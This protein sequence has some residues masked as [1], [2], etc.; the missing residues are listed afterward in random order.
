MARITAFVGLQWLI[1]PDPISDNVAYDD[2]PRRDVPHI[3]T[4]ISRVRQGNR[5]GE[6]A[7][8]LSTLWESNPSLPPL[9]KLCSSPVA[10]DEG[11]MCVSCVQK[12]K[13]TRFADS[14]VPC[15]R[16]LGISGRQGWE[17]IPVTVLPAAP[18]P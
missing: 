17:F 1:L 10:D 16:H 13:A 14:R 12:R 2:I 8:S 18:I 4:L 9:R 7:G 15:L 11:S 5:E 3:A 6:L